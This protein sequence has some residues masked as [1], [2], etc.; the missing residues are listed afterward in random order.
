M[1]RKFHKFHTGIKISFNIHH[2]LEYASYDLC[3]CGHEDSCSWLGDY[4]AAYLPLTDRP[5]LTTDGDS[6]PEVHQAFIYPRIPESLSYQAKNLVS[7]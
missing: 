6:P 1:Q 7:N 4:L 5:V 2:S 3:E